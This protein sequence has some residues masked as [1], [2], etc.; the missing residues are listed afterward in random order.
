MRSKERNRDLSE[1]PI[2]PVGTES[3]PLSTQPS[4]RRIDAKTAAIILLVIVLVPIIAG[5]AIKYTELDRQYNTLRTDYRT[6]NN[7]HNA[8]QNNYENL[9]T[10]YQTLNTSYKTLNQKYTT[11]D[12]KYTTLNDKYTNLNNVYANINS[13]YATLSSQYATLNQQY[14]SLFQDYD[15]LSQAFNEPLAHEVIPTNTELENW[16]ATDTTDT[17]GYTMP[18]FICGDFSVMLS[19]HAKLVNWDIGI[20]AVWGYTDT[21]ESFAHAFNAII[22]TEGL[23]YIEP[24][25]DQYW[26]YTGHQEISQGQWWE[27]GDQWIYVEDYSVIVWYD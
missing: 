4:K 10:S 19:Q 6:L 18:D 2:L 24:Q 14:A 15:Q 12:D 21:Y 7:S 13:S 8:L 22:T 27:I 17:I 25:T 9:E 16:L 11:L 5:L 26:W 23:V 3:K 1:P 20:V